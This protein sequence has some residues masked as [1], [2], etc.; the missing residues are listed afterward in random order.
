MPRQRPHSRDKMFFSQKYRKA[1]YRYEIAVCIQTGDIVWI[2]GPFKAGR[3]PDINIFRRTL[4]GKLLP[5]E[6]V[7]ADMGYMDPKCRHSCIVVSRNDA[8]AKAACMARHES[9]NGDLKNFGCL[10]H[11]WRHPLEKHVIAFEACVVLTQIKY[12]MY[13]SPRMQVRY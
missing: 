9:V 11:V 4:K 7:E 3:W 10:A 1:A 6:M 5:H 8:R 13:G 2:N 12:T